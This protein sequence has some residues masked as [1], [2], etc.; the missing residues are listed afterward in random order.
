MTNDKVAY[1][2]SEAAV[3]IINDSSMMIMEGPSSNTPNLSAGAE[4]ITVG[5]HG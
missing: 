4:V 2:D 5:S 1:I 3:H